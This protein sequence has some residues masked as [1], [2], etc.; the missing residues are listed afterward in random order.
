M[1]FRLTAE[2]LPRYLYTWKTN[3]WGILRNLYGGPQAPFGT[4]QFQRRL[5]VALGGGSQALVR[6]TMTVPI[7]DTSGRRGDNSFILG[8]PPKPLFPKS[9]PLDLLSLCLSI[10]VESSPRGVLW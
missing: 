9:S 10:L 2:T 3:L 5:P 1:K 7:Y 4:G 8:S 6:F